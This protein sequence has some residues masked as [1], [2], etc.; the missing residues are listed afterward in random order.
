MSTFTLTVQE[1]VVETP[2]TR[3]IRLALGQQPFRFAA[4]QAVMAGLHGSPLRRPY[5]IAS[6]PSEATRSG[7]I[8][9][10]VQVDDS[11]GP[12]PHLENAAPGTRLDIDGPF[13]T[14]GLP[15][16]EGRSC[17]LVAGGTGIA[18]L[19]SMLVEALAGPSPPPTSLVYTARRPDEIAYKSELDAIAQQGRLRVIY[20]VTREGG[21]WAGRRGRIDAALLAEALISPNALCLICGPAEM[22]VDAKT[23]LRGLGVP[24]DHLLTDRY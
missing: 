11:G 7:A 17:L 18:P 2:R 8:E 22:V 20:T 12:D 6:S 24:S 13:G 3:I 10:L 4:G 1:V 16:I 9:L 19:R 23:I 14:F 15:P 5:S 21:D